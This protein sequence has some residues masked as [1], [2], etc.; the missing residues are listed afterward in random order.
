MSLSS[1]LWRCVYVCEMRRRRSPV[2]SEGMGRGAM[3]SLLL[4][5]LLGCK[6]GPRA[7]DKR[8]W[9]DLREVEMCWR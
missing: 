9:V 1:S 5:G 4:K 7:Q 8:V 3:L 2:I 6:V